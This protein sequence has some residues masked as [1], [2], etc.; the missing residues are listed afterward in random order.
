M[1]EK[2]TLLLEGLLPADVWNAIIVLL[3]LFGVAV[4]LAKGIAFFRDE[5]QKSRNKKKLNRTDITDEIAEKVMDKLTP[6]INEKFEEFSTSFDK[7]FEDID[8][9]LSSDKE[10]L[11]SH[12]SKL[13]DH[14]DRVSRLEGGN[15]T[16][17]QGMLALLEKDPALTK[18][19]HAMK[20]YLISGK[21]NEKDWE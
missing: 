3:I 5:I 4:A 1:E 6:Q 19:A 21:Y 18:A 9:K 10:L 14:E 2:K 11:K 17:C 20:N 13:N 8:S 15:D 7:K 12:T 16:L